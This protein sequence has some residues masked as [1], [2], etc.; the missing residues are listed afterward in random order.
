MPNLH[1]ENKI[2]EATSKV[3]TNIVFDRSMN[4]RMISTNN[5]DSSLRLPAGR[6]AQNDKKSD[7]EYKNGIMI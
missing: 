4:Y 6:Q 2:Q 7:Q 3:I 1:L 5:L